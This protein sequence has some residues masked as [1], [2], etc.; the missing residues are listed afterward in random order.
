LSEASPINDVLVK[1]PTLR[2]LRNSQKIGESGEFYITLPK[3]QRGVVWSMSQKSQLIDSIFQGFPVGALLGY[4]TGDK[5]T[6]G[7]KPRD[8]YELVDGLQRTT[9]IINFLETPLLFA[10]IDSLIEKETLAAISNIYFGNTAEESLITTKSSVEKWLR[11][12]GTTNRDDGFTESR[13]QRFMREVDGVDVQSNATSQTQEF[14]DFIES[15][16]GQIESLFSQIQNV[17]VPMVIYTGPQQNVPEIF[18]RINTQGIKL[19]K[20]EKFAAAWLHFYTKIENPEIVSSIQ[21]KYQSLI[22][23]GYEVADIGDDDQVDP[24]D[25]NLFEYLFGLGKLLSK[26]FTYLFPESK[27]PDES[28]SVAFVIATVAH[29][30]KISQMGSLAK[31]L[32]EKQDGSGQVMLSAFEKAV[33]DSASEVEKAIKAFMRVNL[34]NQSSA[35]RFLPH[36]QNQIISMVVRYMIETHNTNDWSKRVSKNK[37]V[38]LTNFKAF[39]LYDIIQ[40]KWSGSGDSKLWDVCWEGNENDMLGT[41][42]SNQYLVAPTREQWSGVLDAWHG[43]QLQKSQ[44]ERERVTGEAKLFLKYV[45]SDIVTVAQDEAQSFDIEHLYSVAHLSEAIRATNSEDGWPISAVG[46]LAI[47]PVEINR[48]KGSQMLGDYLA[49]DTS[50]GMTASMVKNLQKY[51]YSPDVEQIVSSRVLSKKEYETFCKE[52]FEALKVHLL[53]QISRGTET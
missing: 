17:K 29:G 39:Y 34:N 49:S 4:K 35:T 51:V 45:Y 32:K 50:S 28:P 26:K 53:D 8:I 10:P 27:E 7:K 24:D 33:I 15:W 23:R 9:T 31:F 44:R 47:L 38:L 13:F 21:A 3:F 20:Y 46:N 18:E 43:G 14:Q 40:G 6:T 37:D 42:P 52:R 16:L 48:K 2:E 11:E 36:S 25:F 19:S 41:L 1:T 12:V 22:A 5:E 30:I